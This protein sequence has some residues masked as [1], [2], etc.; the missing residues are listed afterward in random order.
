MAGT[1]EARLANWFPN[2][3]LWRTRWDLNRLNIEHSRCDH[4]VIGFTMSKINLGHNKQM[5]CRQK[6]PMMKP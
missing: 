5:D 4:V 6:C 1:R 3:G 2:S